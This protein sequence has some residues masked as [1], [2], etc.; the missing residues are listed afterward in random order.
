MKN[1]LY[2][3]IFALLPLAFTACSTGD[4]DTEEWRRANWDAYT[5]VM[6]NPAYKQVTTETGPTGVYYEELEKGTGTE[7]P[8]Q[9]ATVKIWYT[10]T[11]YDGTVFLV[12]S[13]QNDVPVELQVSGSTV[14][15][16]L[17]FALQNMVIGDKWKIWM[18]Y[19]L[20][21]GTYAT[22]SVKAYSTLVYEVELISFNNWP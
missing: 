16:G 12:G 2:L 15:R 8:I 21:F 22:T 4:D 14:P 13:S 20:G 9:T 19:T 10:G 3:S 5:A 18:P 11:Y 1:L 7:H 17:S 6:E